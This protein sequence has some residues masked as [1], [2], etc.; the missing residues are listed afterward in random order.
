MRGERRSGGSAVDKSVFR[1][2]VTSLEK[3]R[4]GGARVAK[5]EVRVED[6][7]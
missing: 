2:L 6:F 3:M 7:L 5:E 1:G 4:I